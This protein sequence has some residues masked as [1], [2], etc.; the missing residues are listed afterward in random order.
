[1]GLTATNL[2]TLQLLNIVNKTSNAQSKALTQLSTG[3][4]INKASDDPAGL[5]AVENFN[6]ELT[7]ANAALE[8]NQR[9]NAMLSTAEGGL[10]EISSLLLEV[11]KLAV[12]S[13]N[14]ASLSGAERSANQAQIDAALA[15]IDRIANTTTFNGK[16]LLNG[17][18]AIDATGIAANTVENLQ[19]YSR[20]SSEND[21]DVSVEVLTAAA[22]AK[23]T[24]TLASGAKTTDAETVIE[25]QGTLGT[26]T[27]S[28]AQNA[29][30]NDIRDAINSVTD[31]T[32]VQAAT[33]GNDVVLSS[34]DG[35]TLATG[36][37]E[38]VSLTVISGGTMSSGGNVID[39]DR[40][41][42]VDAVV[43]INGRSITADGELI[44]YSEGGYSLGFN[45]GTSLDAVG[46]TEVF[47]V[48]ASGGMTFQLGT[49]SN[50]RSTLGIDAVTSSRL[51]ETG[52]T[53]TSLAQIRSGGSADLNSKSANTLQAVRGAISQVAAIKGRIGGFQKFQVE[54][55][56]NSLTQRTEA[57]T[58][59]RSA[60]ADTDFAAA[61][62]ELNRQSVLLNSGISLLGLANQQASQILSLLG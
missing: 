60:I 32:G 56:I 8:N 57:L 5:I 17:S 19:I 48:K 53:G 38:S 42:G 4:R 46:N 6:A 14:D 52:T 49:E 16:S 55:S 24:I 34:G 28:V 10:T 58:A 35:T 47:T 41:E 23:A 7:A 39:L 2:N 22:E 27:V 30:D 44:S 62:A 20:G 12:A 31:I 13:V 18:Q 37:D 1:M 61:S 15:S 51:G 3:F 33:V 9:S 25:I 26:A 29:I 11:E 50:T 43:E 21:I 45:L 36:T 59:A 54:T 40:Q